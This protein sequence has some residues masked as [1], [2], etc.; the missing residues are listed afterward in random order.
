MTVPEYLSL[1]AAVEQAV[2]LYLGSVRAGFLTLSIHLLSME[3]I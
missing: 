3:H 1:L 2:E